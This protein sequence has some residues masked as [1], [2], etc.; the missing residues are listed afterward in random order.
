MLLTAVTAIIF[1][2]VLPRAASAA[3]VKLEWDASTSAALAGYEVHYGNT[4]SGKY[5]R[6]RDVGNKTYDTV[7]DLTA[8][9]W[10]FAVR[11]YG[12]SG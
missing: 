7:P 3:E 9:T 10:Y 11:A 2:I 6:V 1:I 8:G 4:T 12:K 5:S